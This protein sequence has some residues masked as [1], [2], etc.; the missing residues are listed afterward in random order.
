MH[1]L[2]GF[3]CK[4]LTVAG[5]WMYVRTSKSGKP[6]RSRFKRNWKRTREDISCPAE[7]E[8]YRA[9]PAELVGA[10]AGPRQV[11][12]PAQSGPF[13]RLDIGARNLPVSLACE[14]V[15]KKYTKRCELPVSQT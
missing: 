1:S 2:Q 13:R 9:D 4:P 15:C 14:A 10:K 7:V 12:W 5:C 3:K 6:F 8:V 11:S